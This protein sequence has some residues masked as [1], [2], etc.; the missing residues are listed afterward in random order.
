MRRQ[1]RS[2]KPIGVVVAMRP[3]CHERAPRTRPLAPAC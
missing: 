1:A 2:T 3:C